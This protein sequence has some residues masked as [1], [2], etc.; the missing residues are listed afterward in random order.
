MPS[1]AEHIFQASTA[2][3]SIIQK[4]GKKEQEDSQP[5]VQNVT[6]NVRNSFDGLLLDLVICHGWNPDHH[7]LLLRTD[8]ATYRAMSK[9]MC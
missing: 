9:Q 7:L 3:Q 8:E 4:R 6:V 2:E 1:F 5:E